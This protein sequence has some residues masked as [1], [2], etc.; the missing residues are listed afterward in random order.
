MRWSGQAFYCSNEDGDP[1]Y[2]GH[3]FKSEDQ[4]GP[5]HIP[6]YLLLVIFLFYWKFVSLA[7][8][9]YCFISVLILQFSLVFFKK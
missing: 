8:R 5:P 7:K 1:D 3:C 6:L 4:E 2:L 9:V